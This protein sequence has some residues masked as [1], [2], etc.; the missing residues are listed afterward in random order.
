MRVALLPHGMREWSPRFICGRTRDFQSRDGACR[1]LARPRRVPPLALTPG[2]TVSPGCPHSLPHAPP[3]MPRYFVRAPFS[4]HTPVDRSKR[5]TGCWAVR[6]R[7]N[8]LSL[9]VWHFTQRFV[10]PRR[11]VGYPRQ[12]PKGMQSHLGPKVYPCMGL[13]G[14]GF[15]HG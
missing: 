10:L 9:G 5:V 8:P 1:G 2:P 13:F 11:W 7:A 6:A 15:G 3:R 12:R 14:F 4:L